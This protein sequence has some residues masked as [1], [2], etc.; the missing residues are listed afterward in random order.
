M[1][2]KSSSA[3]LPNRRTVLITGAAQRIGKAI[4]LGFAEKQWNVLIHYHQSHEAAEA[5]VKTIAAEGGTAMSFAADLSQEQ[6][7]ADLIP[8][9]AKTIQKPID[10]LVNNASIFERDDAATATAQSWQLHMQINLRAPFILSQKFQQQ[11]PAGRH[12]NIINVIDQRVLCLT[13]Y[14]TSYTI[15]KA[16]LWTLTQTLALAWA[17]YIRVNAIG[18]GPTLPSPRQT[19]KQFQDQCLA[20]PLQQGTSP[21]EISNAIQFIVDSPAM[22]GQ[23]LSLDGGQHLGWAVPSKNYILPE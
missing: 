19:S 20:M 21:E 9:I 11:L 7:T 23:M 5:L 18:P 2:N 15:S 10:C 22:T 4:A 6:E 8:I 13:P 17:P 14:F 12:A 16:G 1:V 3:L